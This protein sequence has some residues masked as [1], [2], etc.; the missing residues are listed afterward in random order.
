VK[1]LLVLIVLY[2]PDADAWGLQ[3]HVFFAQYALALVPLADPE[4]RAA[5]ARLPRLV[6]AGAC[7]PDLAIIGKFFLRSPVFA[8]SHRWATLRRLAAGPRSDEECAL[9]V[10]YATHLVSDVI[11]HNQFVP[12]HEARIG[13]GF[14]LA[15]L[16]SEWAMDHHVD[17]D[18][19]PA[20][21]LEEARAHAVGFVAR[22]FRCGE[23]LVRRGLDILARGE[24]VLRR[25]PAP[26]L[27]RKAV[28]LMDRNWETRF[29]LYLSRTAQGLRMLEAALGGAF[30]DWC[31]SDPEGSGADELTSSGGVPSR[32][33]CP[34]TLR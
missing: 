21:V 20:D 6:L 23:P 12:E 8:R 29:D 11:A 7:L 17:V 3:T 13:R 18:V 25:S 5:A 19:Q 24:R 14:M 4:L 32:A 31:G 34:P 27:C 26:A 15:H 10:G 9:A 22:G 33:A 16:L 1:A 30:E 28:R 2:A